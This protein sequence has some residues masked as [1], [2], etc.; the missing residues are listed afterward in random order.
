MTINYFYW[1]HKQG[2]LSVSDGNVFSCIFYYLLFSLENCVAIIIIIGYRIYHSVWSKLCLPHWPKVNESKRLSLSLCLFVF[3]L[4]LLF[5][6]FLSLN[7]EKIPHSNQTHHLH[8]PNKEIRRLSLSSWEFS[9]AFYCILHVVEN[10]H[11]M[12]LIQN[13]CIERII[14]LKYIIITN[15]KYEFIVSSFDPFWLITF[16]G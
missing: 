1:A 10:Q 13:Q 9:I 7:K 5:T 14:E 8:H 12:N 6:A 2:I 11:K 4:L 15:S 16:S 3:P